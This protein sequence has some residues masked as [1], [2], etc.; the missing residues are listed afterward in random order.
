[1][2]DFDFERANANPLPE[3]LQIIFEECDP[4]ILDGSKKTFRIVSK[5]S[6]YRSLADLVLPQ[7]DL[8]N[9]DI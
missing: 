3:K 9:V 2:R 5:D 1:L 4:L 6:A 7:D 8:V